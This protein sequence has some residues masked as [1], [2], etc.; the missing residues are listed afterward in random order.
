MLTSVF[1][2][3]VFFFPICN[4]LITDVIY[5]FLSN[6]QTRRKFIVFWHEMVAFFREK[7][8]S[9]L[10]SELTLQWKRS[11]GSARRN[12]IGNEKSNGRFYDRQVEAIFYVMCYVVIKLLYMPANFFLW[13]TTLNWFSKFIWFSR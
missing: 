6:W 9:L 10:I 7:I 3:H 4:N 8:V 12:S 2:F 13:F 11:N 5:Y 1:V